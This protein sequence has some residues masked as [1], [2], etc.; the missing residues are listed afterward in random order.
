MVDRKSVLTVAQLQAPK[1]PP[2][3]SLWH[4]ASPNTCSI[5]HQA[6]LNRFMER[7]LVA[8]G[9]SSSI[10]RSATIQ[11]GYT[12]SF[13]QALVNAPDPFLARVAARCTSAEP[14]YLDVMYCQSG[15][16]PVSEK[17]YSFLTF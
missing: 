2:C 15:F 13:F 14:A 1:P 3:G 4:H 5:G 16:V 12:T 7:F 9:R 10:F 8:H 11:P 17:K 6:F